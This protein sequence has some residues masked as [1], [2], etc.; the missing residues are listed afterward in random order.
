M[1][2]ESGKDKKFFWKQLKIQGCGRASQSGRGS[3]NTNKIEADEWNIERKEIS[4]RLILAFL[5]QGVRRGRG[6]RRRL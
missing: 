3:S 6:R 4:P 5:I 2:P 1:R